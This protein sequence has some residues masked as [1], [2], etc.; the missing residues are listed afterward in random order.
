M[1]KPSHFL[2]LDLGAESGRAIVGTLAGDRLG[3]EECHRFP[4]RPLSLPTGLHWDIPTLW[5][6]IQHGI[7]AAAHRY[8]LASLALDGWGV[9]FALLDEKGALLGPPH[10]YRD[11]RTDGMVAEAF[12]RVPREQIFAQTGIQFM[13][14]N[15]LY[16]LLA[17]AQAGDPQLAAARTFLTIPDLFNAWLSGSRCCEFTNATTTQCLDPHTRTWALP[18]LEALGI[19]GAIFPTLCEPGTTLGPLLPAVA[20]EVTAAAAGAADTVV[21]AGELPVIAPACHDTGSAVVAIPAENAGFAWISS[22]TWSIMGAELDQPNL[23]PQAL[24]FN[25]TNEGGVCGTW[26][27][28][29][30]VM[31]LWLVQECKR[32]WDLSYAELTRLAAEARPFLAVIDPDAPLFLHPGGMPE[33]IRAFCRASGQAVPETQGEL[34]RVVLE[35]LALKYRLTLTQLEALT[36]ARLE[37]VHIIGGGTQNRLLN[38]L[39]ADCTGR[40]VVAGP[41]EA[42]A[43]GNIAVQAIARGRLESLTQARAVVRRSFEVEVYQPGARAGW[44]EGYAMLLS[45]VDGAALEEHYSG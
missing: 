43:L 30:N 25:F 1:M 40:P 2:A 44:D 27:L 16:Q 26:R 11:A 3:L 13:Q 14:I 33:R 17:M 36:G 8:P 19:P 38:Q 4:N 34:V 20:R 10:T 24:A 31:G 21:A 12:R 29:K 9:D 37:P 6:E 15:T 22:G 28:S 41:V 39:T 7:A 23:S 35:S 18:L 32:E 45:L 5:R 42:T